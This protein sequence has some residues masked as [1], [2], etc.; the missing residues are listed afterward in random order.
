MAGR[1]IDT[2]EVR[3]CFT[4]RS[5]TTIL[6]EEEEEEGA[7]KICAFFSLYNNNF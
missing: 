7:H 4:G 5:A 6:Q 3:A 1:C 2:G